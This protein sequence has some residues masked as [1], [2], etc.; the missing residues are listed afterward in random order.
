M[1]GGLLS[2]PTL[3][4]CVYTAA[5]TPS[6]NSLVFIPSPEIRRPWQPLY[7]AQN[8]HTRMRIRSR[9]QRPIKI[10]LQIRIRQLFDHA[11]LCHCEVYR[12]KDAMSL[13][14]TPETTK[15]VPMTGEAAAGQGPT[16]KNEFKKPLLKQR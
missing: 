9:D 14:T 5:H 8:D 10:V 13:K 1:G 7:R 6:E 12:L 4:Y 3:V 11:L 2:K 15:T 16:P